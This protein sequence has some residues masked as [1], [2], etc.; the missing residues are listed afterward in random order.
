MCQ[1]NYSME[2]QNINEI[3][4]FNREKIKLLFKEKNV[5]SIQIPKV[6]HFYRN[7][8]IYFNEVRLCSDN[9]RLEYCYTDDGHHYIMNETEMKKILYVENKIL[10]KVY[11]QLIQL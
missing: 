3:A 5:Q 1:N 9:N 10:F 6:R 11:E 2:L 4:A 8:F 7:G